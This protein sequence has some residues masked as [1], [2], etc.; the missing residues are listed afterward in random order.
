M[1][2]LVGLLLVV[3]IIAITY[4]GVE[5]LGLSALFGIVLPY[6]AVACFI[7]GFI[8]RIVKWAK[9]PVPFRIPTTCGQQKSLDSSNKIR[10]KILPAKAG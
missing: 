2:I 9:S 8:Y 3:A 1:S 4:I 7:I 5:V 10:L 6:V